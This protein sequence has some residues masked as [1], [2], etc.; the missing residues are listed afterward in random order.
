MLS[1]PAAA[2]VTQALCGL[3][4][5]KNGDNPLMFLSEP[6]KKRTFVAFLILTSALPGVWLLE[7]LLPENVSVVAGGL[8]LVLALGGGFLY[9]V[10]TKC[11][12]CHKA[13]KKITASR[14]LRALL[15]W[16]PN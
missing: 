11:P 15:W 1:G 16:P 8:Y 6:H 14:C 3:D 13:F 4:K 10:R 12:H 2:R 9:A 7:H 5:Q